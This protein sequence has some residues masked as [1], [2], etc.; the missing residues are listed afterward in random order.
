[1]SWYPSA[2]RKP[3]TGTSTAR[4]QK[5]IL[6]FHTAVGYLVSTWNYFERDDIK[7]YSHGCI[8]GKW[9]SDIARDLDGVAWQMADTDVRAAANLD[10]NYR[11]ISWETADN[12]AR[13][14]QP[15]TPA[16]C[17]KIVQIMVDANRLDGIPLVMIPDSKPGRR[18]VGYHRLGCDPYRVAGGEL[19]SSSPG[20]DCPTD[21]RIKQLPAL[22]DQAKD[23]VAGKPGGSFMTYT[24]AEEKRVLDAADAILGMTALGQPSAGA[25]LKALL[26]AIQNLTNLVGAKTGSLA[27]N[28]NDAKTA[29]V[30]AVASAPT[31]HLDPADQAA[32]AQAIAAEIAKIGIDPID[33][34]AL[35]AAVAADLGQRLES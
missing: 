34:A 19:W 12:A 8:G 2:V 21:P 20:K 35:S 3:L 14:I 23:I 17:A 25:T 30:T 32:I 22:L 7:V 29:I 9:G 31:A 33:S 16:Q 5:D 27:T 6:C 24:P 11:V 15:W 26:P 1:V 28:I 4:L 18:G 10:G 13:P